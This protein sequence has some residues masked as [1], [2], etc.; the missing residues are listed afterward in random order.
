MSGPKTR[1]TDL[2][3]LED[4]MV[5]ASAP[6]VRDNGDALEV[7]DLWRD[8]STIPQTWKVWDG[9]DWQSMGG[10]DTGRV[11]MPL[12]TVVAGEPELVWDD[13]DSLIPTEVP[14]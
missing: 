8:T 9:T 1:V 13:D 14:T 10:A 5:S 3:G 11:W 4:V 2:A 12:T 6:S 7:D